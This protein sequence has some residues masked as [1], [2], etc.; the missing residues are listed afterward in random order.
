M[1]V[2]DGTQN[3]LL[4]NGALL[5][6]AARPKPMTEMG[7]EAKSRTRKPPYCQ[8]KHDV[9]AAKASA[10]PSQIVEKEA[11]PL[12]AVRCQNLAGHLRKV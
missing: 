8:A 11:E 7:R 6:V 4:D 12:S 2:G 5:P 3:N 1:P 9:V 10:A